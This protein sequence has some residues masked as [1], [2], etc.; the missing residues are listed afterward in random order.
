MEEQKNLTFELQEKGPK[1]EK[2][3]EKRVTHADAI[4]K[5][6][7]SKIFGEYKKVFNSIQGLAA[8]SEKLLKEKRKEELASF[9][10]RATREG[11]NFSRCQMDKVI[12]AYASGK[13]VEFETFSPYLADYGMATGEIWENNL[14]KADTIGLG[15]GKMLRENFSNARVI[16]LYDE[17]NSNV[18]DSSDIYG[19]PVTDGAQL[20]FA[21]EAK[22]S[23]KKNV[24]LVMRNNGIIRE[25]DTEGKNFLLLS[26][27]SKAKD[28]EALVQKLEA[29]GKIKRDGEEIIFKNPDAENPEYAEITLKTKN[30]RW[31]C[32]TLD[33][34]TYLKPEN[35][36]ITHLV[37]LPNHFKKQQDKVWEILRILGI[38]TTNYHN[39]FFDENT[40]PEA[41]VRVIQE[42]IERNT[43]EFKMDKENH[44][45]MAA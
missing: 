10:T 24:E 19:K 12:A 29:L 23:F 4:P 30:G 18:P 27:S 40:S 14:I 39:I 3:G 13:P 44:L 43:K 41:A 5:K 37:I 11:V 1:E 28:A 25:G 35:V 17:Y 9:E 42:E 32:E 15:I 22:E 16:S 34:S 21:P 20:A 38:E 7:W 36:E 45:S 31:L 8:Q 33:A 2:V 26:E 6:P